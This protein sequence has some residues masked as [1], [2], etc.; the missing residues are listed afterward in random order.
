VGEQDEEIYEAVT[1]VGPNDR[2]T[3]L[4][5]VAKKHLALDHFTI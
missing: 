3:D 2:H 1:P 5:V 4:K